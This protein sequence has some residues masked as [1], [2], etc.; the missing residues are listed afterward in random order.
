MKVTV[1]QSSLPWLLLLL[2]MVIRMMKGQT[3]W[4]ATSREIIRA[5]SRGGTGLRLRDA[6]RSAIRIRVVASRVVRK[7]VTA[8]LLSRASSKPR[9]SD[10]PDSLDLE[11]VLDHHRHPPAGRT[12]PPAAIA[13]AI[14]EPARKERERGQPYDRGVQACERGK[15]SKPSTHAERALKPPSDLHHDHESVDCHGLGDLLPSIASRWSRPP[16]QAAQ[17]SVTAE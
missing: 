5:G 6:P 1:A 10:A 14:D 15:C 3:C 8:R 9:D 16:L 13:A 12:E 11:I 17:A 7:E 4:R 2:A